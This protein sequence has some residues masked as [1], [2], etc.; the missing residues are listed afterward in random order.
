[1]DHTVGVPLKNEE[2][3]NG[4]HYFDGAVRRWSGRVRTSQGLVCLVYYTY[5]LYRYFVTACRS[6]C[7][8]LLPFSEPAC[9]SIG[10]VCFGSGQ[11]VYCGRHGY[12]VCFFVV[13]ERELFPFSCACV[14]SAE[15]V[16]CLCVV[17]C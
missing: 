10:V 11:V 4:V 14:V 2:I 6:A 3:L 8:R 17:F 7:M 16:A 5:F 12:I 9:H 13:W 1:M 15:C